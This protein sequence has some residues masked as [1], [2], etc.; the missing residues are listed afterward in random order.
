MGEMGSRSGT[1]ASGTWKRLFGNRDLRIVLQL[2]KTAVGNDVPGINAFDG[3]LA[4]VCDAWLDVANLS[5][6]VLDEID[7]CGLAVMLNSGGRNQRDPLP[8]VHQ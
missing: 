3:G 8:C 2:F 7:E 5:D 1:L 4:G 6:A